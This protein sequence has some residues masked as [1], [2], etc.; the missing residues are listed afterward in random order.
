[1]KYKNLH[2][3]KFQEDA[4]KGIE[5]N[6]S[7]VVSAPTG[8]GKTLIADYIVNKDVKKG[9]RVIYTAP[10]KALS[11]QKYKDF[12]EEYG[13]EKIGLL[14]GDIVKNPSAPVLIMTTEIY[15]NMALTNDPIMDKISYVIFD[16]IHYINDIDRGYVWEESIIFSKPNVRFLCLSATIPNADEFAKWIEAIKKHKV[17]VIVHNERVVPLEKK[18]FDTELGITPLRGISDVNSIPD[19]NQVMGKKRFKRNRITPPSHIELIKDIQDKLP[20]LF[21]NF[22][23]KKC[24]DNALGLMKSKL[25]ELNPKIRSFVRN[26]LESSPKE[27]KNLESSKLLFRT[28]PYG[29]GFHHAGLLPIIKEIVEELFEK[30]LIKVLYTTETFAV[31]INM[32]AKTV[33]FESL[34][35]YDGINFRFLNSKEYFQIAGRAGRRGIDTEGFVY[36]MIQRRDFDFSKIKKITEKDIDPIKSQFKLSVNTVLNLIKNHTQEEIDTILKNNFYTFQKYGKSFSKIKNNTF[37]VTFEKTKNKLT[38]LNFILNDKLTEKGEFSSMIYADEILTGEIFST[39]FYHDLNEYQILMILASICYESREK[40]EIYKLYPSKFITD[41]VK[42]IRNNEFI[43]KDRR[44]RY[45]GELTGLIHPCYDGKS[46]FDIMKN[47]NLNEGDLIRFFRQILDRLNQIK[48]A[49]QDQRL[50][51]MLKSLQDLVYNCLRN[52]D[53]V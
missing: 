22:S 50:Q 3:D 35:K 23:R 31:G 41:L 25:F 2:L 46:I 52:I 14:T 32:P 42:D 24:Q 13:K 51:Q 7:V 16:E 30:G 29:I 27:I 53:T 10:I 6:H 47:T 36:A 15:R 45:L 9:I 39:E 26:K 18:F 40:T 44:F 38:K 21:F 19:Y 28:L 34:R 17:E 33:C 11:N 4:I 20:C 5:N 43:K 48:Q 1:M 12:C 49:T 37:F 8:C